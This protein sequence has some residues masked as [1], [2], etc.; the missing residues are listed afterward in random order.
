MH[1]TTNIIHRDIKLE[2]IAIETDYKGQVLIKLLD[3]GLSKM[4][5]NNRQTRTLI[6]RGTLDYIAP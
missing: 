6:G 4:C 2:N 5:E 1:K 3:F